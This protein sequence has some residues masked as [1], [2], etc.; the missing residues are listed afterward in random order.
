MNETEKK[1]YLLE[2]GDLLFNRTNSKELVGKCNVFNLNGNYVF[3]SYL[4]RVR[5]IQGKLLPDYVVAY[6]SSSIGRLQIDAVSR[7][8]A[9][10]TNINAEEIRD[11]LIPV[12]PM[13]VQWKVVEAWKGA[14]QK[15][16]QTIAASRHLLLSI[17]G[18]LLAELG[19]TPKPAP[20]NTI[21]NRIFKRP[22]SEVTGG[23]LDPIANQPKRV[24]LE[25]TIISG[26]YPTKP[27]YALVSFRKDIVNDIVPGI[28][29]IG[30]ENIDGLTGR[31]IETREKESISSALIFS[32]RQ[33]LFPKLRPYLNKTHLSEF[34]GLCS[35]EFH[36]LDAHAVKPEFLTEFLRSQATVAL[37]SLLMTGNTLPRL[38]LADIERLQVPVPPLK[39][40]DE[41]TARI[42][43][44]RRSSYDLFKDAQINLEEAKKGIEAII[45]GEGGK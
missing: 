3:A 6:L 29:Y 37:I 17:D 43:E 13:G 36:V 22:L 30:L 40:Q 20:P 45:M 42:A 9:G 24:I 27:L 5:L 41:L 32:P 2:Q 11:L 15:R 18:L 14:I 7:Q 38:Q 26:K 23:R 4:I 10:M 16:D 34:S 12:P 21:E 19:I 44:I 35:T 8:I 28:S 25:S 1:S 31:Y 39:V 33:I